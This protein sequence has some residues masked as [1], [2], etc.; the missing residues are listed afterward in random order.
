MVQPP[1]LL[2]T[3][4]FQWA[5]FQHNKLTVIHAMPFKKVFR[6][7]G[8]FFALMKPPSFF[9][10]HGSATHIALLQART[11][12]LI[13]RRHLYKKNRSRLPSILSFSFFL[14]LKYFYSSSLTWVISTSG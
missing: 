4:L 13:D 3:T 1:L 5:Y 10:P 12:Y 7:G 2:L 9:N 11:Q 14:F 6:I 8:V